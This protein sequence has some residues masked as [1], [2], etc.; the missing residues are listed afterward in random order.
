MDVWRRWLLC[1]AASAAV[2]RTGRHVE[3]TGQDSWRDQWPHKHRAEQQ[4][5]EQHGNEKCF[6]AQVARAAAGFIVIF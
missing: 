3:E 4:R 5:F 2:G 6:A 1:G